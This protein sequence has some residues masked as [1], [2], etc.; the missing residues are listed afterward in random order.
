VG[1]GGAAEHWVER[2]GR[3]RRLTTA[4]RSCGGAPARCGAWE[5]GNEA[6]C[7]CMSA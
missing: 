5:E 2:V 1:G 4:G 6:K 7:E 3:R